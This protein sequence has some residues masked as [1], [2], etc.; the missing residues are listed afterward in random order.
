[1]QP[2]H[3]IPILNNMPSKRKRELWR[4]L[5]IKNVVSTAARVIVVVDDWID[6]DKHNL[7][8]KYTYTF[9]QI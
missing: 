9:R 5:K 7:V 6:D 8:K 2:V 3:S 1:M 4:G